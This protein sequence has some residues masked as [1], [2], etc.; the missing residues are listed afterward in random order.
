V[1]GIHLKRALR[2]IRNHR[3]L[4]VVTICTIALSIL[5]ISAAM[6][7]FLNTGDILDAWREGLRVMVYLR[8]GLNDDQRQALANQ[9]K[10]QPGVDSVVFIDKD[11]ALANLRQ[12]MQHQ[13]SIIDGLAQNPLPDAFEVR[14]NT[15][16]RDW[17]KVEALV[18]SL[19]T[20]EAVTDVEYGQ[21][22]VER[23]ITIFHLFRFTGYTM[24]GLFF[25]ASIFIVGNTV[26]L[27]LY[28]RREEVEI[29]RL[30]G[31]TDGF[32]LMPFYF[33]SLIQGALGGILG[34]LV[35]VLIYSGIQAKMAEVAIAGI[36]QLR[37]L[38]SATMGVI[39]VGSMLV[40][41]L[42]CHLSLRQFLKT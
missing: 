20:L 22:W 6:L 18:Q 42:G 4:N 31:A 17:T 7:F 10:T 12:Q 32:I 3:T 35:L 30:V 21:R 36:F 26:R 13:A 19:E 23:L 16:S 11:T 14:M 29:M 5:V 37:F 39:V 8:D 41:W 34:L 28:A 15:A 2:D 38:P 27:I 40:G 9:I 33:Q 1:I 25:L 24:G